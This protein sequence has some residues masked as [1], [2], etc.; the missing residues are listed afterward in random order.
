M[1]DTIQ[2]R[3]DR[4]MSQRGKS[5]CLHGTYIIVDIQHY[6]AKIPYVCE[7][8]I[9]MIMKASCQAIYMT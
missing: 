8:S 6:E 4:V 9:F 2:A 3:G 1:S 7:F 5:P